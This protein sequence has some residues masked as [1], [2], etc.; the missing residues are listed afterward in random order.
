M[1]A[2]ISENGPIFSLSMNVGKGSN[3]QCFAGED[4]ITEEMS[5]LETG[6]KLCILCSISCCNSMYLGLACSASVN[7]N[8]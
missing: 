7:C 4:E 8:W 1:L 6:I 2:I 3:S 5:L